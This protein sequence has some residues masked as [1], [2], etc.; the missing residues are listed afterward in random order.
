MK[1]VVFN[2]YCKREKKERKKEREENTEKP[3]EKSLRVPA[4]LA[5][6]D[7]LGDNEAEN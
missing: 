7:Y 3:R 2:K 6:V 5:M 1:E 4:F